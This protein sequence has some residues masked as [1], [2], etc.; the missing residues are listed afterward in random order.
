VRRSSSVSLLVM[1]DW[2]GSER[3]G[4]NISSGSKKKITQPERSVLSRRATLLSSSPHVRVIRGESVAHL[5]FLDL[6][7]PLPRSTTSSRGAAPRVIHSKPPPA[8]GV[9]G[10]TAPP[11]HRH[12]KAL[13]VVKRRD[14]ERQGTTWRSH[15]PNHNRPRLR[16]DPLHRCLDSA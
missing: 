14:G 5:W 11:S 7:L 13:S 3:S 6:S 12:A 15:A 1:F 10:V 9:R 2:K 8:H 16:R 4:L